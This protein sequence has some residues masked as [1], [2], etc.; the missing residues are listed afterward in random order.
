LIHVARRIGATGENAMGRNIGRSVTIGVVGVAA[1]IAGGMMAARY[2][3]GGIDPFYQHASSAGDTLGSD[4]AVVHGDAFLPATGDNAGATPLAALPT[5]TAP[6]ETTHDDWDMID[7]QMQREL[8]R[9][10]KLADAPLPDYDFAEPGDYAAPPPAPR[11]R[12]APVVP[13]TAVGPA[14]PNGTLIY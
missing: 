6:P 8:D 1:C 3:V 13:D 5:V 7:P 10:L 14:T 12:R 2:A 11:Q 9:A 4:V